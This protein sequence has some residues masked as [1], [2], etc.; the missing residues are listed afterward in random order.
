MALI[1]PSPSAGA[2]LLTLSG[3]LDLLNTLDLNSGE[4]IVDGE[5][6]STLAGPTW[7]ATFGG[8]IDASIWDVASLGF[9]YEAH[10]WTAGSAFRLEPDKERLKDWKSKLVWE[11]T[12]WEIGAE[13][14]LTRTRSWFILDAE[15]TVPGA[16]EGIDAE[17]R[18][19]FRSK[20]CGTVSFYDADVTLE[21]GIC[22]KDFGV[23]AEFDTGG[24]DA[25]TLAVEGLVAGNLPWLI[26]DLEIERSATD[27]D[28]DIDPTIEITPT[29]CIEFEAETSFTAGVLGPIQI[30]SVSAT[31]DVGAIELEGEFYVDPNEWIDDVYFARITLE[32]G[33]SIGKQ[34]PL[35]ATV[36]V[37]LSSTGVR[38]GPARVV[39]DTEFE[40]SGST[41]LHLST[42][43]GDG[44][45]DTLSVGVSTTW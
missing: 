8:E 24:L 2:E 16:D 25:L 10:G 20:P 45:S 27:L 18:L 28:I 4:A 22:H 43:F 5:W 31:C 36:Q 15:G 23:G 17:G 40:W 19:R 21:W 33:W 32:G 1:I 26:W 44:G 11:G 6:E 3:C 39:V 30:F 42:T 41:T 35:D 29:T 13:H 34:R 9:E 38:L 7:E 12:H 14:K 37:L